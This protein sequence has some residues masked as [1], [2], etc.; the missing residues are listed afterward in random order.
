MV[1]LLAAVGAIMSA[2]AGLVHGAL[3]WVVITNG[4]AASGLVAYLALP[5]QKKPFQH[6]L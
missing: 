4:A 1:G 6:N 2:L 3:V 5:P